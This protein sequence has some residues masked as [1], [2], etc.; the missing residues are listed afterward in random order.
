MIWRIVTGILALGSMAAAF[1]QYRKRDEDRTRLNAKIAELE[2][3]IAKKEQEFAELRTR[4]DAKNAQVR[5]L[6]QE[7]LRLREELAYLQRTGAELF[8]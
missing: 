6:A 7:I 4:F 1:D 3:R 2:I 5:E 8:T